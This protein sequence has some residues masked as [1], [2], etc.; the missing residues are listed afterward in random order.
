MRTTQLSTLQHTKVFKK[1]VARTGLYIDDH[2][3][4]DVLQVLS[5]VIGD[6]AGQRG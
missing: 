1:H 3:T 4:V 5:I 6:G 2:V